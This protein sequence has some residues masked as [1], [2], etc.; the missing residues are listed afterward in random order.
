MVSWIMSAGFCRVSSVLRRVSSAVSAGS[1]RFGSGCQER[2]RWPPLAGDVDRFG[3]VTVRDFPPDISEDEFSELLRGTGASVL[4]C[5]WLGPGEDRLP[6]FATHQVGVAGA[7]VDESNGK[8]L[9]VQDRNKTKNAW[10]F[11]G[12]LSD[13]GENIGETAVREVF[14]ETGVRSQFCSLLSIRQQHNHPGAFGMSD[15]YLI[16]RLSPL[17]FRIDFCTQECLR[18]EWLDLTELAE[19]G[20]TTPITSRVARLLLYGLENGFQNID[21]TMEQMP[22]VYSGLFYQLYHRR[23]P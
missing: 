10:K 6:S 5:F 3:G 4:T 21:L 19:T 11:P 1:A 2:L 20:E 23:L 14:E 13:L 8:V 9:V 7:V 16:C 15:M 22:A 17:S 18:C 12:G